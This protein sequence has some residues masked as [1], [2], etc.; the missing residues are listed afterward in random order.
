M[1]APIMAKP[2]TTLM[3]DTMTHDNPI[4]NWPHEFPLYRPYNRPLALPH[5]QEL[6]SNGFVKALSTKIYEKID[7]NECVV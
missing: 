1:T 2:M 5:D 3:I 6:S 4:Y 7:A